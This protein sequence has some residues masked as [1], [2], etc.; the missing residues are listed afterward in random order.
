MLKQP[1]SLIIV[2]TNGTYYFNKFVHFVFTIV[3]TFEVLTLGL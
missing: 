2:W 3:L 1:K